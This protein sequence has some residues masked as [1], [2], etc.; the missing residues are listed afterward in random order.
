MPLAAAKGLEMRNTGNIKYYRKQ[1]VTGK[2]VFQGQWLSLEYASQDKLMPMTAVSGTTMAA[3][4]I[5]IEN[6][7]TS[8]AAALVTAV[9]FNNCEVLCD[10]TGVSVGQV[11]SYL[12]AA[13]DATD[14]VIGLLTRGNPVGILVELQG[15]SKGWIDVA[16]YGRFAPGT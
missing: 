10:L 6:N 8:L 2:T 11:G 16:N 1:V 4:G 13:G 9:Y 14:K 3:V 15:T 12:Y 5:A 7:A